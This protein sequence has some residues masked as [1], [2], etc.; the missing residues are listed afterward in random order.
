[1]RRSKTD[2]GDLEAKLELRRHF[3]L[4][5]H[6]RGHTSVL[7]CCQGNGIIW[8]TLRIEFGFAYWGIDVKPRKGRLTMDSSRILEQP[9]WTQ[10]VVDID[11]YGSPWKHWAAMLP[12]IVRSTTVFLTIGAIMFTGAVD[13]V[14]REAMGLRFQNLP[15]PPSIC[16][17]L[18]DLAVGYSLAKCHRYGIRIIEAQ[19]ALSDGNAQYIGIRLESP[20]QAI[21]RA[22]KLNGA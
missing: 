6:A 11:T 2:N 17:K 15:L 19:K 7:D 5:Y 4:K 21:D 18:N 3:L 12:N 10:N 1:M 22:G 16:G 9:G 14:A 20:E 13:G 8:S